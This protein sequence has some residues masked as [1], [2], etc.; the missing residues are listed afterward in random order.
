MTWVWLRLATEQ[1]K[2]GTTCSGGTLSQNEMQLPLEYTEGAPLHPLFALEARNLGYL[3]AIC[4]PRRHKQTAPKLQSCEK[5]ME[6][7]DVQKL[8]KV[9]A[10]ATLPLRA[11]RF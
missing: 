3:A 10:S 6:T 11:R 2:L 4:A 1:A 9:K 5:Q 7:P 8:V